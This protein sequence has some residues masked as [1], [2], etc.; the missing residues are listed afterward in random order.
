M[1]LKAP[2]NSKELMIVK[3]VNYTLNYDLLLAITHKTTHAWRCFRLIK[4]LHY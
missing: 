1:E 4:P 3:I 2:C